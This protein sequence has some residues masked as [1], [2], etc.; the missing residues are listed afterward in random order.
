[1]MSS[2]FLENKNSTWL[3]YGIR[4][5]VLPIFVENKALYSTR[6]PPLEDID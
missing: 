2:L 4:I 1:M 5:D 3:A 6:S